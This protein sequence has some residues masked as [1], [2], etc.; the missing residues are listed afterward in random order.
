[1]HEPLHH[2]DAGGTVTQDGVRNNGPPQRLRHFACRDLA[3]AQR[4]AGEVPQ[5]ALAALWFVDREQLITAARKTY[6]ER[7]VRRP[8]HPAEHLDV[9]V[10]QDRARGLF[11]DRVD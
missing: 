9:A 2:A 4:A 3:S 6:E 11:V 8:R 5:W 10:A 1:M 7:R